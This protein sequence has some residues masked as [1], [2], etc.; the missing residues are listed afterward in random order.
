MRADLQAALPKETPIESFLQVVLSSAVNTPKLLDTTPASFLGCVRQLAYLGLSPDKVM[1]E[2]ALIPY[3]TVC[4]L[5]VMYRGLMRLAY[6]GGIVEMLECRTVY[7][8]DKFD[9][10]FGVNTK[11]EHRPS[12]DPDRGKPTFY[13]ALA[14]LN[15]GHVL[16]DVMS[17][18]EIDEVRKKYSRSGNDGPWVTEPVPMSLKTVLR[19]LLKYLPKSPTPLQR[20]IAL[21]ERAEAGISQE[22]EL[23]I[24]L[25][26]ETDTPNGE[27]KPETKLG[28]LKEKIKDQTPPPAAKPPVVQEPPKTQAPP[29]NP[30]AAAPA[31]AIIDAEEV[32]KEPERTDET[33]QAVGGSAPVEQAQSNVPLTPPPAPEEKQNRFDAE[34]VSKVQTL[35]ELANKKKISLEEVDEYSRD[36]YGKSI[37]RLEKVNLDSVIDRVNNWPLKTQFFVKKA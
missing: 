10:C 27:K 13:Y 1:G 33:E 18:A 36:K 29:E 6:Q 25:Q 22:I 14:R 31:P 7:E 16:F 35:M 9:W 5:V 15:G 23:P 12:P 30:P 24:D 32:T 2:A 17:Q 19:R 8:K 11:L 37:M 26:D 21:D 4:T 3:G 20:A 34:S 28:K